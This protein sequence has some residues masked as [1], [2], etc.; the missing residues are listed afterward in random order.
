MCKNLS[1]TVAHKKGFFQGKVFLSFTKLV[2]AIQSL[3]DA[4]F[5]WE[6]HLQPWIVYFIM[7]LTDISI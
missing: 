3:T 5:I 4:V 7:Y 6:Q 2:A 1:E